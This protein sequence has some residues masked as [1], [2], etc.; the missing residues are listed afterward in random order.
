M[1]TW[2]ALVTIPRT[3]SGKTSAS[4][5][6]FLSMGKITISLPSLKTRLYC[7]PNRTKRNGPFAPVRLHPDV[8]SPK[9]KVQSLGQ[10]CAVRVLASDFGLR[11]SDFGRWIS[12]LT[13]TLP[14]TRSATIPLTLTLLLG[15]PLGRTA[16]AQTLDQKLAVEESIRREHDMITL[17]HKLADAQNAQARHDLPNAAKLYDECWDLVLRIGN[18][19]QPQTRLTRAG[20]TAVR[21][22]LAKDAQHRGDYRAAA[23]DI[24]D[25]VRVD[26]TNV[27][28]L[29]F[30]RANQKLL[31]A[32]RGR[33]PS[34]DAVGQI[35]GIISNKVTVGTLVQD[36]KLFLEMRKVD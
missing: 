14:M 6:A 16:L 17:N 21:F 26:R 2:P 8:Q 11:T 29:E 1:A 19:P 36:G 3:T 23:V 13:A 5:P 22:E 31:D 35:S 27:Q 4:A 10:C 24:D 20:L 18:E 25:V 32:M 28:A 34:D 15:V 30:K 33:T 9:S 12:F 7:P